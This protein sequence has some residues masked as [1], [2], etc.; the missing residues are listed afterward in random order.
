MT[1]KEC[2]KSYPLN[3]LVGNYWNDNCMN[4]EYIKINKNQ[5]NFWE[6]VKSK[7]WKMDNH[8]YFTI[9]DGFYNV[10]KGYIFIYDPIKGYISIADDDNSFFPAVNPNNNTWHAIDYLDSCVD[11]IIAPDKELW[12]KLSE[13]KHVPLNA[14]ND[15]QWMQEQVAYA[16]D[17][18]KYEAGYVFTTNEELK[19]FIEENF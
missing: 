13:I 19:K 16:F 4:G 8:F 3:T 6:V 9:Y 5:K 15:I 18:Q 14:Y 7:F 2:V 1:F 10:I 11:S 12:E 17:K